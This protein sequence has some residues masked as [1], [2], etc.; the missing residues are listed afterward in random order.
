[1]TQ[2]NKLKNTSN[3]KRQKTDQFP[4]N[5]TFIVT[6]QSYIQ[7]SKLEQLNTLFRLELYRR[8]DFFEITIRMQLTKP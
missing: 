5:S 6:N 3:H 8:M 1:M 2:K 4:Y 7:K